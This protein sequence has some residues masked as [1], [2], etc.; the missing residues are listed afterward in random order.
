ML[1]DERDLW[2]QGRYVTTHLIVRTEYLRAHPDVVER[3]VRGQVEASE[4]VSS[5]STEAQSLANS[6]IA[7]IAGKSL[8]PDVIARAWSNLTFTDDPIA[9]SLRTSARNA[10]RLG[11][12]KPVDL[13]GIY[14]LALLNSVLRA[15]EKPEVRAA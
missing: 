15:R 13:L 5:H 6:A 9:S 2:P 1:V 10:E 11:L 12:L 8:P 7:K 3:L 4:F 14:D